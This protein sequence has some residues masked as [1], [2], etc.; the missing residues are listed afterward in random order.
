MAEPIAHEALDQLFLSART[1]GKWRDVPVAD[2]LLVQLAGLVALGPTSANCEPARLAFVKSPEAKKRL[3]PYLDQGNLDKTMAAP[4]CAIIAYDTQFYDNLPRL[5]P[6]ADARSWFVGD[7]AK[8]M[9]T[10][11]RSGSLQGTYLIMAAR[12]LGLDAGPMSGF[13]NAGVD[14]EFFPGGR[15]KSNF[16]CNLG[17]GDP[18]ALKP[19]LPRL[20]FGDMA[21]II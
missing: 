4:V 18:L 7:D 13:D 16:L 3:A 20:E 12:A 9:E 5:F 19:R 21:E 6:H 14:R 2:E 11:F 8:V 15:L 10:A 1:H 17:Y